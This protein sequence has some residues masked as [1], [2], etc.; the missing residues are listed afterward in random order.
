MIKKWSIKIII[1]SVSGVLSAWSQ[2]WHKFVMALYKALQSLQSNGITL[3]S[4]G[5][6][7]QSN[8]I[9]YGRDLGV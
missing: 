8:G 7:L 3:Q 1:C 6:K 2:N 9:T 5:I 4:N